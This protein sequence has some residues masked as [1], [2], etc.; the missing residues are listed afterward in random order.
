[1]PTLSLDEIKKAVDDIIGTKGDNTIQEYVISCLED[2]TFEFGEEGE[3][4]FHA[5]GE[6]LVRP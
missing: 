6:M 3:E 2:D 5:F 4:A 1:M